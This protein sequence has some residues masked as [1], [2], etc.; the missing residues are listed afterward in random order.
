M[1]LFYKKH[2][3]KTKRKTEIQFLSRK[4][5]TNTG[6]QSLLT[7]VRE[8]FSIFV[9]PAMWDSTRCWLLQ[10]NKQALPR[11]ACGMAHIQ[12]R[13]LGHIPVLRRHD[14]RAARAT[15]LHDCNNRRSVADSAVAHGHNLRIRAR[16][17]RQVHENVRL[18]RTMRGS[19]YCPLYPN[20][21]SYTP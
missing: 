2:L 11:E 5:K 1:F 16:A 8:G 15:A 12:Q 7:P 10:T 19:Y 18:N 13:V 21:L 6:H 9:M 3:Y 20:I 4:F 14:T 17:A